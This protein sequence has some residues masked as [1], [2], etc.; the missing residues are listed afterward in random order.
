MVYVCFPVTFVVET[1]RK[2]EVT[3]LEILQ[4]WGM[5]LDCAKL[6]SQNYL[7]FGERVLLLM[8]FCRYQ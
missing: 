8:W 1:G 6:H 3:Q 5:F 2:I 4:K 7:L